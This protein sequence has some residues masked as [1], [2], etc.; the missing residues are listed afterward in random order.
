MLAGE[1][2]DPNGNYAAQFKKLLKVVEDAK[3]DMCDNAGYD[4]IVIED[5]HEVFLEELKKL[6]G[7]KATYE[8]A[9]K[10][11]GD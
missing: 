5:F 10:I 8:E 4:E 2:P 3:K 6:E 1:K 9:Q 11:A 7:I